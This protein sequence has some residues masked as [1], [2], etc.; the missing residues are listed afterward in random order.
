MTVSDGSM[1]RIDAALRSYGFVLYS[2]PPSVRARWPSILACLEVAIAVALYW[3][4]AL[5]FDTQKHLWVSICVAPLLLLRSE[6]STALGIKWFA[7]Y[8]ARN[9]TLRKMTAAEGVRAKSF[10]WVIGLSAVASTTISYSVACLWLVD[11]TGWPLF[12]RSAF[13]GWLS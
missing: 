7:A 13:L 5:H 6:E 3:W 12:W 10:W 11:Q 9:N 8:I 2:T 1:V 4:I